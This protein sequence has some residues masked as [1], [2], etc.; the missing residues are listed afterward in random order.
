MANRNRDEWLRPTNLVVMVSPT[1]T[2]V[3]M[4]VACQIAFTLIALPL[5]SQQ[6]ARPV[7]RLDAWMISQPYPNNPLRLATLEGS[8][9]IAGETRSADLQIECR[10][11]QLARLNLLFRAN[12]EF[13]LD[14]FEGPPGIGQKRKLLAMPLGEGP[15]RTYFFSG[16]YVE[17]NRFVF[18]FAPS[19]ADVWGLL[20]NESAGKPIRIQVSPADGKGDPLIFSFTLPADNAPARNIAQP[21]VESKDKNREPDPR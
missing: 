9:A 2:R 16:F 12:L 13:N 17:S 18:A 4:R 5:W 10:A 14:P 6:V 1:M 11:P 8:V 15:P 7:P 19:R 20:S 3:R 21:C